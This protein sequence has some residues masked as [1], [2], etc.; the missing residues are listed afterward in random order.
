MLKSSK[1]L[2]FYNPDLRLMRRSRYLDFIGKNVVALRNITD[3]ANAR[4]INEKLHLPLFQLGAYFVGQTRA[5]E[6]ICYVL[7]NTDD[8]SLLVYDKDALSFSILAEPELISMNKL[9]ENTT[10]IYESLMTFSVQYRIN[11][12]LVSIDLREIKSRWGD[13]PQD[14]EMLFD[15]ADGYIKLMK[16]CYSLC[17]DSVSSSDP[18]A[19]A[20][21]IYKEAEIIGMRA[22]NKLMETGGCFAN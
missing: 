15:G 9:I 5:R 1:A 12:R 17:S 4:Y 14:S 22:F 19:M 16:E 10:K 3:A 8:T 6:D 13:R 18:E 7:E 2:F 11:D 20:Q 21:A